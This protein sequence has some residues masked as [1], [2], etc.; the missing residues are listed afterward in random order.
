MSRDFYFYKKI[1]KGTLRSFEIFL[2]II[3]NLRDHLL[4]SRV[5]TF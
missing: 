1:S 2:M 4:A 3:E 5:Q